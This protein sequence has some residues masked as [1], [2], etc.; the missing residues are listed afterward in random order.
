MTTVNIE[1]I[2]PLEYRAFAEFCNAVADSAPQ[3]MAESDARQLR[4]Y[5]G[6]A[7]GL[8][9]RNTAISAFE[10]A[11]ASVVPAASAA[12]SVVKPTRS[13][14]AKEEPVKETAGQPN[15]SADPE[16]RIDPA[17][18]EDEAQDAAD[19]AA[20]TETARDPAKP[21]TLED[22]KAAVMKY[23]IKFELPAA[24]QDGVGIFGSVLGTPPAGQDY[25]KMSIIPD[26]PDA[27]AKCVA[28]WEAAAAKP[29]RTQA[30]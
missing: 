30:A 1:L 8:A 28:A 14:K 2:H 17:N 3:I 29:E 27:Y 25:W 13:R 23:V 5:G 20:D 11:Y 6:P 22:V 7:G 9:E 15:I 10:T 19:E 12:P 26:D 4:L 18:P 24:Q 21:F 16:N